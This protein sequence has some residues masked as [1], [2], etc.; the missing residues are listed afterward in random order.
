[1]I[2]NCLPIVKDQPFVVKGAFGFGLKAI[3]KNMYK[4]KLVFN[5]ARY[6]MKILNTLFKKVINNPKKYIKNK[7]FYNF[8]KERMVCDFI[9]GMTDRYAI[10][11]YNS[12][13]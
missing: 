13:K 7:F 5:K 11:L 1:M 2:L 9:A 4:H 12:I 10:N 6:G 8:S 3:A